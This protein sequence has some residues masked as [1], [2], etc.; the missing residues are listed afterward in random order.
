MESKILKVSRVT[1]DHGT[2][3]EPALDQSWT[4]IK[5]LCWHAAVVQLDTGIHIEVDFAN[6]TR[7]GKKQHGFYDV[8]V[9]A[10]TAGPFTFQAAWSYLNGVD[11]GVRVMKQRLI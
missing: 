1:T 4:P 9:G 7:G 6:Y 3:I 8:K 2:H 11:T 5:K 10:S